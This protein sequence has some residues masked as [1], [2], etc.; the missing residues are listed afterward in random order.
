MQT[1]SVHRPNKTKP[2]DPTSRLWAHV[3]GVDIPLHTQP[4]V[5]SPV[6]S[7]SSAQ[8]QQSGATTAD[9]TPQ[10]DNVG[11]TVAGLHA[12]IA[13]LQAQL[14]QAT[15][16]QQPPNETITPIHKPLGEAGSNGRGFNLR[17][18]M[19]LSD[20]LQKQVLYRA[21]LRTVKINCLKYGIDVR[22]S[23]RRQDPEVLAK[24][25]KAGCRMHEYLTPRRFPLHWA[26]ACIVKQ[27]LSN[28]CKYYRRRQQAMEQGS[29][30]DSESSADAVV[31]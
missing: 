17:D 10:S 19:L 1:P 26:Q 8:A 11:M 22:M 3:G 7:T 12:T 29:P 31:V 18:A 4:G 20:T 9:T 15:T 23:Y 14:S 30:D 16:A 5:P 2:V 27:W 13:S 21:I 24:V 6:S 28:T 25:F